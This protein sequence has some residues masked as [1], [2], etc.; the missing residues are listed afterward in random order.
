MDAQFVA[1]LKTPIP[2]ELAGPLPRKTRLSAK[3]IPLV[4]G[5]TILLAVAV[6]CT[7]YALIQAIPELQKKSALRL[8]GSEVIGRVQSSSIPFIDYAFA[9]NGISYSAKVRLPEYI[10]ANS[11]LSESYRE[12]SPILIR[13]LPENPAINHPAAWQWPAFEDLGWFLAALVTGTFGSLFVL[14]L[15]SDRQLVV[16]GR[17][18]AAMVTG[19]HEAGRGGLRTTYEFRMDDGRVIQGS[20]RSINRQNVGACLWVLYLPQNPKR[21]QAYSGLSYAVAL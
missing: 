6:G 15:R 14:F 21:F 18:R 8:H 9:I 13:Y 12:S 4:L 2:S 20:S 16:H 3:G 5:A 19:C 1:V 10:I 17:P 7:S 11:V